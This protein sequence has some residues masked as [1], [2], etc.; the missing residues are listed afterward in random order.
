MNHPQTDEQ[1]GRSFAVTFA[2]VVVIVCLVAIVGFGAAVYL[3]LSEKAGRT[4][5]AEQ[6]EEQAAELRAA[7]DRASLDLSEL[8]A[9]GVVQY[10]NLQSAVL[11]QKVEYEALKARPAEPKTLRFEQRAVEIEPL[12]YPEPVETGVWTGVLRIDGDKPARYTMPFEGLRAIQLYPENSPR[13]Q[14]TPLAFNQDRSKFF[15]VDGLST[16]RRF[17][18]ETLQEEVRLTLGATC[19]DMELTANGLA[20]SFPA[21]GKIWMIDPQTLKVTGEIAMQHPT[22]LA[23]TATSEH[24]F[25]IGHQQAIA[26]RPDTLEVEK[27]IPFTRHGR[28]EGSENTFNNGVLTFTMHPDQQTLL[29]C[30]S[31]S[32]Y[33][34]HRFAITETGIEFVDSARATPKRG[35]SPMVLSP[36]GQL[37]AVPQ[38]MYGPGMHPRLYVKDA[39][40][41]KRTKLVI[42]A[43]ARFLACGFD[44]TTGKIVAVGENKRVY[45][46]N[47]IGELEKKYGRADLGNVDRITPLPAGDRYLIWSDTGMWIEDLNP[48]HLKA[49]IPEQ[50][51]G[52]PEQ[53]SP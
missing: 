46:F 31:G 52:H 10:T 8:R 35:Y 25:A 13:H 44:T 42:K 6:H 33:G 21:R 12:G 9:D 28:L 14:R 24:V 15:I 5:A 16:L 29:T 30:T 48:A 20:L 51:H 34:I 11:E 32:N 26:F 41:P 17:D 23:A 38:P 50:D 7:I 45:V 1:Q 43:D 2:K 3:W 47:S 39:N 40:D 18:S 53:A 19:Y 27:T 37:L 4:I 22:H 49:V 36:D